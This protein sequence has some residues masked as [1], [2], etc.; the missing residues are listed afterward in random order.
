MTLY[1]LGLIL[2]ETRQFEAAITA[3]RNSVATFR[4][5]GDRMRESMALLHLELTR[6]A[7]LA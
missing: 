2:H 3:L 7:Q 6:A 1:N 5:T 4:E